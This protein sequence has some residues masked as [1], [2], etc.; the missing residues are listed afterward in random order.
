MN[1]RAQ[2][3]ARHYRA[4]VGNTMGRSK[5][6]A[7]FIASAQQSLASGQPGD[8]G[9]CNRNASHDERRRHLNWLQTQSFLA[10]LADYR[11]QKETNR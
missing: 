2:F 3:I 4:D 7:F 9:P 8:A 1:P 10:Q 6:L 5:S 11:A